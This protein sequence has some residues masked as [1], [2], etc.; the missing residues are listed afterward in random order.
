MSILVV[1]GVSP[2]LLC[3]VH[4]LMFYLLCD[5]YDA[6]PSDYVSM[7]I[8]DYGMVSCNNVLNFCSLIN[9]QKGE[10]AEKNW[11][12]LISL[13]VYLFSTIKDF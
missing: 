6:T 4:W 5:S 10:N 2:G 12:L 11:F 9:Y 13:L 1:H 7:I 3:T 8:T